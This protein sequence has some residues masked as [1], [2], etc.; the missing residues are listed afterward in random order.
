MSVLG[1]TALG[2]AVSSMAAVTVGAGFASAEAGPDGRYYGSMAVEVVDGKAHTIW[3]TDYP[4]WEESDASALGR[5]VSGHCSVIVRFVDGCG[6]IAV[7]NGSMIGRSAP[8]KAEAER[9]AIDA[10]GPPVASLSAAPVQAS[11]L[12]T[13]CTHNAG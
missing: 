10:F 7:K 8:S 5:C 3:A 11:I 13:A 9:A 4:S 12:Q 2:L 6:S 1:K